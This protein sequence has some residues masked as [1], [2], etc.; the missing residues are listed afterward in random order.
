MS[1][2]K[3]LNV[4][5]VAMTTATYKLQGNEIEKNDMNSWNMQPEK[6]KGN[7]NAILS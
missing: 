7:D 5:S 2:S 6:S 3:P 1:P 4:P